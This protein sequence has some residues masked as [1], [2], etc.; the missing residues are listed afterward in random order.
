[1]HK[2]TRNFSMST[3]KLMKNLHKMKANFRACYAAFSQHR[4]KFLSTSVDQQQARSSI[5]QLLITR[6]DFRFWFVA[7]KSLST[8]SAINRAVIKR[9]WS[10]ARN[11]H[12]LRK[13]GCR[14]WSKQTRK[15]GLL[16]KFDG[17]ESI[18]LSRKRESLRSS[19][20]GVRRLSKHSFYSRL[21]VMFHL[22]KQFQALT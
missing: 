20:L 12:K 15:Q 10:P 11:Y 9:W 21:D 19:Q 17:Q 16:V 2:L 18:G 4:L 8:L 13:F 5:K 7:R 3:W 14:G 6:I 22:R 1:M